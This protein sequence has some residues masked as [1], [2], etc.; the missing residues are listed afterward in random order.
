M[1]NGGRFEE[2]RTD[3]WQRQREAQWAWPMRIL[4]LLSLLLFICVSALLSLVGCARRKGAASWLRA[5]TGDTDT[6]QQHLVFN[7]GVCGQTRAAIRRLASVSICSVI[8]PVHAF[9]AS[10]IV[11]YE[12]CLSFISTLYRQSS[13]IAVLKKSITCEVVGRRERIPIHCSTNSWRA[14]NG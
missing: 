2:M 6:V 11:C 7:G 5:V 12:F 10:Y 8:L 9:Y 13:Y 4:V 14:S 1:E 3:F